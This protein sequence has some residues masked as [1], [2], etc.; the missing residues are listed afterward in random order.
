MCFE[1]FLY[2]QERCASDI[3]QHL[4]PF[5]PPRAPCLPP[6]ID[7]FNC[8]NCCFYNKLSW[9]LNYRYSF[10]ITSF[11]Y[12]IFQIFHYI[13]YIEEEY[14]GWFGWFMIFNVT[15]NNISVISWWS[16]LLMEGAWVPRENHR[17]AT[18][19]WRYHI[20]KKCC[21]EYTSPWT[22]FELT[23]NE[24]SMGVKPI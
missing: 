18:S 17:P 5:S 21:I 8:Q 1:I 13:Y 16:V 14:I 7:F 12:Y 6:K 3:N 24:Y 10:A 2:L 22:W 15:F 23:A 11:I 20:K 4:K 19:N 9:Y